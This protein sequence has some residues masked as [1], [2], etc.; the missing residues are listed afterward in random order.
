MPH[1]N[2]GPGEK[3][4]TSSRGEGPPVICYGDG[5]AVSLR[6][7]K[8]SQ[9]I[10]ASGEMEAAI[11]K[12]QEQFKKGLSGRRI[13]DFRS[14]EAD[15]H[16]EVA[17]MEHCAKRWQTKEGTYQLKRRRL[18]PDVRDPPEQGNA[19]VDMKDIHDFANFHWTW[20]V[21]FACGL[22]GAWFCF[23]FVVFPV[24]FLHSIRVSLH[25]E[26]PVVDRLCLVLARQCRK[27]KGQP[28][29]PL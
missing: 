11:A 6:E 16:A 27:K 24:K 5:C 10:I 23:C 14:K 22:L 26:F 13:T 1:T 21:G 29:K 28:E 25:F 17:F 2:R 19:E 3:V 4:G 20:C 15:A 12:N 18:L 9:I 7:D 8:G